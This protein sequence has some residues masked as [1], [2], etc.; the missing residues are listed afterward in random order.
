MQENGRERKIDIH[1]G[2]TIWNSH[3]IEKRQ[4]VG[5]SIQ[6]EDSG[7]VGCWGAGKAL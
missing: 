3:F 7:S 5:G 2:N 1:V 4:T 6:A